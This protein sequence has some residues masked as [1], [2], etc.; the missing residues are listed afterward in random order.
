MTQEFGRVFFRICQAKVLVQR[1]PDQ[2]K[3]LPVAMER[4]ERMQQGDGYARRLRRSPANSGLFF[5][6][7]DSDCSPNTSFISLDST[8]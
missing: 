6:A 8:C 1:N 5:F 3:K 7:G 2:Q 4:D